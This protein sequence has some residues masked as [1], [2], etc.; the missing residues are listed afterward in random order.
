[1]G[2]GC[3]GT[4]IRG[5]LP[6]RRRGDRLRAQGYLGNPLC[7]SET[8]VRAHISRKKK[9]RKSQGDLLPNVSELVS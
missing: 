9:Q 3:D 2:A 7:E 4:D 1:M 8:H 6:N 5:G